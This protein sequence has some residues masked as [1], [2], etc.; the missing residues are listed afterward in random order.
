MK[1]WEQVFIDGSACESC[2][3]HATFDERHP[4]GGT[5]SVERLRDC[6]ETS[7]SQCPGV[8]D[9]ERGETKH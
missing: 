2:A 6:L 3:M 8:E 9:G 7:K 1:T 4:Y 5:F